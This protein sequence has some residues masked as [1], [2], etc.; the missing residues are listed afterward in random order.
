[1]IR[2]R[3]KKYNTTCPNCHGDNVELVNQINDEKGHWKKEEFFCHD[4]AC[5]WDWTY[6]RPFFRW[7]G[8]LKIRAPR[9]VRI[10]WW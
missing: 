5:E 8:R 2:L 4:C 6:E 3:S 7:R 10:D 1:M 9:W